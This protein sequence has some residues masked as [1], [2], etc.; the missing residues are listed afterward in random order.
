ME[1]LSL[2][3]LS[4]FFV[5]SFATSAV[6]STFLISLAKS[7]ASSAAFDAVFP[8]LKNFLPHLNMVFPPG[9]IDTPTAT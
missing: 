2:C 7:A 6:D 3:L 1:I 9:I 8:L 4:D 5:V